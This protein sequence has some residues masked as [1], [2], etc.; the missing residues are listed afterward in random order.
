MVP[1]VPVT[2][3]LKY[4]I[5]DTTGALRDFTRDTSPTLFIPAGSVGFGTTN[6]SIEE[7][8][9]PV[10]PGTFLR[11]INTGARTMHIPVAIRA[12]TF[13]NLLVV[14]DTL[15][16]WFDTGDENRKQPVYLR[17]T[18]PDDSQRQI[19]SYYI[20]GL[21]GD[22]N[23]GSPTFVKYVLDMHCPDPAPTDIANTV[24]TKT[25]A[26]AIGPFG[27][28]NQGSLNA[29]PIWKLI[30]PFFGTV[31]IYNA[32]TNESFS[33][34]TN[35]AAVNVN[36]G[37]GH[38]WIIDTRPSDVKQT[39]S[40]YD[41]AGLPQTSHVFPT[42]KFFQLIPGQNNLTVTFT[43]LTTSA[44]QVQLSYLARYRGLVR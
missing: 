12:S 29:Y 19:A 41:D 25:V 13:G 10:S 9:L 21:E 6:F 20:G 36:V 27:V 14:I 16:Q 8:K 39:V 31:N 40:V 26:Q 34:V 30:G 3:K 32:T 5:I 42:S 37:V 2:G 22:L 15:Q 7:N 18:R 24:I 44:T 23:E 1:P 35:A 43:S 11:R 38:Y 17:V 4:E 28:I 33:L